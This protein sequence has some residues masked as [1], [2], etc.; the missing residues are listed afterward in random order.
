MS[1]S[2]MTWNKK[3]SNTCCKLH[4]SNKRYSLQASAL[5]L[6]LT[7]S[8]S[9]KM[10]RLLM[11]QSWKISC[12]SGLH[13]SY[14]KYRQ[15]YQ[16]TLLLNVCT[17]IKCLLRNVLLEVSTTV[18]TKAGQPRAATVHSQ[19]TCLVQPQRLP[20]HSW[21]QPLHL[22]CA[23]EPALMPT[24]VHP[25]KM[26]NAMIVQKQFYLNALPSTKGR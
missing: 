14:L 5:K 3:V 12:I 9:W 21:A 10:Y 23:H 15:L 20:S 16:I 11:A 26:K 25:I 19:A 7:V 6:V 17:C 24:W 18:C 2:A 22:P 1:K 13:Y 8:C 4:H